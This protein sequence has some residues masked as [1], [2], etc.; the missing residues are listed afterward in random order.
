MRSGMNLPE[1]AYRRL[2]RK[3]VYILGYAVAFAYIVAL[4]ALDPRESNLF[5]KCVLYMFTDLKCAA[6]GGQ[7]A[8][9]CLL[10]GEFLRAIRYNCYLTIFMP[11]FVIGLYKGPFAKTAW[12]PYF[13]IAVMMLYTIARN[14]PGANF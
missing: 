14:L 4:F 6:C 2:M 5:P 12:Y 8:A 10:H 1:R 9:Y 3:G 7:R 11:L 13:G